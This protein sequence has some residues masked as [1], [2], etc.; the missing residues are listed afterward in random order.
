M[1]LNPYIILLSF[2]LIHFLVLRLL[3]RS[4]PHL[5]I[6]MF[7]ATEEFLYY[8]SAAFNPKTPLNQIDYLITYYNSFSQSFISLFSLVF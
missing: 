4:L 7:V 2:H 5:P 6:D 1:F 3:L 8:L